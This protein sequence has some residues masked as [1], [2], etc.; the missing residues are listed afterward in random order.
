[1][2]TDRVLSE[3]DLEDMVSQSLANFGKPTILTP[4]NMSHMGWYPNPEYSGTS[5]EDQYRMSK[6]EHAFA[7]LHVFLWKLKVLPNEGNRE[8]HQ[9]AVKRLKRAKWARYQKPKKV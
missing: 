4:M 7:R 8:L 5:W 6:R 9:L 2:K 3:K 1:M